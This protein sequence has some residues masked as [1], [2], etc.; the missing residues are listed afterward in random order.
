M[1]VRWVGRWQPFCISPETA[2]WGRKCETKR[3]HIE[4]T[5]SILA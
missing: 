2:G 4:A 5:M 3:C 1:P